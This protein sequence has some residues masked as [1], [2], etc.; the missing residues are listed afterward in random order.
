MTCAVS[1]SQRSMRLL[2]RSLN[3]QAAPIAEID[4]TFGPAHAR[5]QLLQKHDG[6][7]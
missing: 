1:S 4:R 2:G 7:V 3:S 5:M 6:N